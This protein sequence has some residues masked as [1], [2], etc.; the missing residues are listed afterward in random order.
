MWTNP[1]PVY[2]GFL[3]STV[4]LYL[5]W[6]RPQVGEELLDSFAPPWHSLEGGS[7]IYRIAVLLLFLV[8]LVLTILMIVGR[9]RSN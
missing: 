6:V 5:F 8:M 3:I 1:L 2:I 9:F 4:L 7:C